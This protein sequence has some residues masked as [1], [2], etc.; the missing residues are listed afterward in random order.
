MLLPETESGIGMETSISN[1]H[2]ER[3]GNGVSNDVPGAQKR[4][5]R[6]YQRERSRVVLSQNTA[7]GKR[8][9]ATVIVEQGLFLL[10]IHRLWVVINYG[11]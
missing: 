4:G 3:E 6:L 8:N 9:A 2:R 10:C 5:W 7:P 11:D 1:N